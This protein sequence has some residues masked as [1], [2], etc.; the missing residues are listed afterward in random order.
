MQSMQSDLAEPPDTAEEPPHPWDDVPLSQWQDWRWQLSH[1]LNTVE[2]FARV[3]RLT[4]DE[5]EGLSAP[6]I[7]V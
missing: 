7:F 1:R 6:G 2:D 5:I 3:I 4:P